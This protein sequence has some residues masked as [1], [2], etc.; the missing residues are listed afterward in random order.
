MRLEPAQPVMAGFKHIDM[1]EAVGFVNIYVYV[2]GLSWLNSA[3]KHIKSLWLK[4]SNTALRTALS[5]PVEPAQ[6]V[7]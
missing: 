7:E 3:D 2:E 4:N 6:S 5:L 1:Y